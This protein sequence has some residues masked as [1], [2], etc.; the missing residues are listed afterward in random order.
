MRARRKTMKKT[1]LVL[2]DIQNEYFPGG[3]LELVAPE[4][5]ARRA[6]L[7]LEAARAAGLRVIHVRHENMD[8]QA[9][10]F[11]ADGPGSAIR[12][13]VAPSAGELVVTKHKVDSFA[14]TGLEDYLREEGI[15]E[16]AVCGMM[17]HMCVDA[18]LRAATAR[19][20]PCALIEDA[21]ATRDLEWGGRKVAAADVKAAFYAA[22][23]FFGVRLVDADI[24]A[25]SV[26]S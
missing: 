18:F 12:A 15:E 26:L 23:A 17:T 6:R 8:P 19:D 11:R 16:L 22:F 13:E 7:A 2:I 5:A 25:A 24:W 3:A 21:T 10:R 14:G 1:A 9:T 4:A 20:Y